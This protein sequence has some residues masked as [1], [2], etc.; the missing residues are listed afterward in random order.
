MTCF[1][2][3]IMDL[4]MLLRLLSPPDLASGLV[5]FTLCLNLFHSLFD[6]VWSFIILIFLLIEDFFI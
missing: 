4:Q 2:T 3:I 1:Y 6:T 5:L